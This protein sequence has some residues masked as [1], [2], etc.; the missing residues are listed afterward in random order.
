MSLWEISVGDSKGEKKNVLELVE[1]KKKK[2][3]VDCV[4]NVSKKEK[5]KNMDMTHEKNWK[6]KGVRRK[7]KIQKQRR[8]M[9][10]IVEAWFRMKKIGQNDDISPEF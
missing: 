3:V 6:G 4:F 5:K 10:E 8:C 1:E 2:G 9:R 7:N